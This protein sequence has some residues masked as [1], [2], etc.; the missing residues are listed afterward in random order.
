MRSHR[1][2]VVGM[3]NLGFDDPSQSWCPS[4]NHI[5]PLSTESPIIPGDGRMPANHGHAPGQ[6]KAR[7]LCVSVPVRPS[8]Q[9]QPKGLL[10][11]LNT[12]GHQMSGILALSSVRAF[13]LC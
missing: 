3:L 12:F 10:G 4:G 9:E 2:L 11:H 7:R 13:R 6:G 8:G 5:L 1:T